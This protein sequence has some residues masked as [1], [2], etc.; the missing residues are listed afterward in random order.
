MN[1]PHR[2][3]PRPDWHRDG[4]LRFRWWHR[5]SGRVRFHGRPGLH[6]PC[7]FLRRL[8]RQAA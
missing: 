2:N 7:P 6:R 5:R 3:R 8:L 1:R 4:F